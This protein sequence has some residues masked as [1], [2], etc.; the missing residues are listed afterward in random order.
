MV[1]SS[2]PSCACPTPFTSR[3]AAIPRGAC[4]SLFV[5]GFPASMQRRR[6]SP[7][8]GPRHGCALAERGRVLALPLQQQPDTRPSRMLR[9]KREAS[10][11]AR[12]NPGSQGRAGR[13]KPYS[14]RRSKADGGVVMSP[15]QAK[16]RLRKV[17]NKGGFVGLCVR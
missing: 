13:S 17:R 1:P 8:T 5:S 12:A 16:G 11:E 2:S 9:E 10:G 4:Q 15:K 14:V 6:S 7:S 3:A